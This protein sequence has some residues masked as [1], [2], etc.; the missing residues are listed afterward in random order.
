MRK[1]L[2][3]LVLG[4][5]GSGAGAYAVLR[6]RSRP[7]PDHPFL[8]IATPIVMAHRGGQGLWPPNTLYA[9]EQ[10][11]AL[12]VDVLE[13][14][15]H[16]TADDVLV[17]RHDPT[18]DATTNGSGF[19]RELTLS[20][21]KSLDAG[22]TWTADGGQTFPYRDLGITIPTLEEVLV[23]TPGMRLNIDIKPEDPAVVAPF[24]QILK[25]FDS[26]ERVLVGSFHDPQLR[27]FRQLCPQV[28]TAAG[29]QETSLFFGLVNILLGAAY[30]GLAEVFSIPEYK[31]GLHVVTP[32]FIRGAHAHN[33]QVH[34]WTVNKREDM[35][36]LLDWGADCLITDYPDRL[37][38]L[39]GRLG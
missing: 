11:A 36:R 9:F 34:I 3:R 2:L 5:L 1:R 13:L 10:A 26:M 7:V 28:A 33:M 21:I 30:Q 24:C 38:R 39:L 4:T 23:A 18:V 6:Q 17:V 22:F 35:R 12:G 19:I 15:I 20:E 31:D 8:D 25:D 37:L 27:L 29:V 32:R 14:D 16:R